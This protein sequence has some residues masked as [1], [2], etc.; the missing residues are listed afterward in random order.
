[1]EQVEP[2]NVAIVGGGPGCKAIMDIIF[3]ERLSQLR[4]KLMGVACTNPK[5]VGYQYAQ[6]KS[7][8]TTQD[9]RDLY[10]LKDLNMIIELTGR[11]EVAN[12]ISR[13]KPDSVRFMDHAGAHLFWDVF[14]VEE[15]RIAERKRAEEALR[16]SQER[17]YTVL[18]ACPDPVVVYNM[19]GVS[20]YINPAF[21]KVFGWTPGEILGMRIDYVPDESRSETQ[22]MIDK[23]LAGKSFSGIESR[24]YTKDGKIIDVSISTAIYLNQEGIPGGSVHTLRDITERK[25]VEKALQEAHDELETRV[26]RRTAELAKTTEQLRLE[27]DKRKRVDEELRVAHKDLAIYADEL[28]AANEELSQYAYA[29]S[30]DLKAP[31]RAIHNY[32]DFLRED[33]ESALDKDLEMYLNGLEL[34]VRHGEQLV[35]DLLEFARVGLQVAQT[36]MIDIREFLQE[37]TASMALP[38]DV[39][40]VMGD[41]WPTIDADRTLLWQI[42]QDLI[43]NA[44]KFNHSPRKRVEIGWHPVEEEDRYEVFVRD[45][46]IGI[47][48]RNHEQIFRV[49]Q[50]LHTRQEYGGTGLGLAIA[51]KA[52]SKL[53]GSIRLESEINKGSTFFVTLPK[54]QQER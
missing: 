45:N 40:V 25:R 47:E 9:Y 1:M 11:E 42:F 32:T 36:E 54:T 28:Q 16:E 2:L 27:L 7:I 43:R 26:E 20:I 44:A 34:A 24:R 30:H 12:E 41:D 50:R 48:P 51:K 3:A 8:Y 19:E 21:T 29:V 46:G 17:Y 35:E 5:A 37:L 31:L 53:H 22:M 13:T 52:V 10:K 38:P 14:Q 6:E 33:L 39:E 4:M 49:F 23:V 15:E 18:E